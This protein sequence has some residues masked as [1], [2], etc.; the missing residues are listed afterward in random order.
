MTEL[1][2]IPSRGR[3]YS[4]TRRVRLGDADPSG[5]LRLDALARYLQDVANDDAVDAGLEG[6]MAWVVR[7]LAIAWQRLP[8]LGDDVTL[9]TFCGGFGSRWAERRTSLAVHGRS[10]AEAAALWVSLDPVTGRPKPLTQQFH[11]MYAEA[12]GGRSVGSRLHQPPPPADASCRPWPLRTTDFDA[13]GHVNNAIALAAV[14]DGRPIVGSLVD[15]EAEVEYRAPILPGE[16]VELVSTADAVWLT[17]EGDV[18]VSAAIPE[19]SVEN[20]E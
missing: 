18:R 7:R 8:E 4:V 19:V 17:V 11:D 3:R 6:A 12:A 15:R 14:E 1:V 10:R 13:L 16:A 20:R 2:P 5:R 9:T